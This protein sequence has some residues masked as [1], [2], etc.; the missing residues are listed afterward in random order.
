MP[1]MTMTKAFDVAFSEIRVIR[2]NH[3]EG[4]VDLS[5]NGEV[6]TVSQV[7]CE[8]CEEWGPCAEHL[9]LAQ[10]A[11]AAHKKSLPLPFDA[12]TESNY[13]QWQQLHDSLEPL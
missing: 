3:L 7:R 1:A 5:I 13:R 2:G 12:E 9:D 4:S 8:I 10:A 6:Y 11:V